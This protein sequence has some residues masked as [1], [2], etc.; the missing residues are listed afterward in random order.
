MPT[1]TITIPAEHTG[2][3]LD[4][5]HGHYITRNVIQLAQGWG[6]IV[7]PFAQFAISKYE[8]NGGDEDYPHET[9]QELCDDAIAWLNSG[10]DKC[11]SCNGSKRCFWVDGKHIKSGVI[12]KGCSGSGRGPRIAGQNFPPVIPEGF[13]WSFNDGDFGLYPTILFDIW[14]ADTRQM[15][16]QDEP[17]NEARKTLREAGLVD[18]ETMERLLGQLPDDIA[19]TM[20]G[21]TVEAKPNDN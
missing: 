20:A 5:H 2:C 19:L 3:F 14:D 9:L 17:M 10:Q 11:G 12:C 13:E 4:S 15:I 6:F 8:S 21:F 7:D 16:G 18:G 1:E